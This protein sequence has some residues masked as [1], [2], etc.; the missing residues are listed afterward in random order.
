MFHKRWGISVVGE[1][2]PAVLHG[3]VSVMPWP[4]FI[5]EKGSLVPTGQEAEWASELVWTQRLEEKS[6]ISA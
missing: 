4:S 6:F 2:L 3:V 1:R 5:P